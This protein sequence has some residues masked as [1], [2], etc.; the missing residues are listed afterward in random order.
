MSLIL[1][2]RPNKKGEDQQVIVIEIAGIRAYLTVSKD[3]GN[4]KVTIDA[5]KKL[6][7]VHR[8]TVGEIITMSKVI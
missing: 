2:I 8:S 4:Y 7:N 5:P 3:R 1:S 6:V